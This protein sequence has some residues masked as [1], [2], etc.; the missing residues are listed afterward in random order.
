MSPSSLPCPELD[1]H[2]LTSEEALTELEAFLYEAY[3]AGASAVRVVHGK[4]TGTLRT[5][6]RS[7]LP[8]QSLVKSF[9][10]GWTWEGG[11]GVTIVE[12]AD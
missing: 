9:R 12:L 6:V 1:L 2:R 10:S 7:W 3:C 11:D 8:K 5:R 4:G